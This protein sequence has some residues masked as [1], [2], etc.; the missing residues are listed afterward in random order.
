MTLAERLYRW[1]NRL[2]DRARSPFATDVAHVPPTGSIDHLHGHRYCVLVSYRRD[3]T[4]VAA[5]LWFGVQA[6]R[7][8]FR[9]GAST[10]K[11]TRIRRN[12][13]VRIAPATVRGRPLAAPFTG[14]ARVLGSAEEPL[15]EQVIRSN[16]GWFRRIYLRLLTRRIAAR[17]VEVVPG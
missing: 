3:G 1:T 15:A 11:L 5:P 13:H 2:Y 6:G 7:L 14:R 8:Y 10:A 12:P 17:Y 16:Y 9:T 4:P